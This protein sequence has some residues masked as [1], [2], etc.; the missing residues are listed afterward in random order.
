MSADMARPW[1]AVVTRESLAGGVIVP[2][3]TRTLRSR[4]EL[5]ALRG[6]ITA[7]M[8]DCD[9]PGAD[10]ADREE[11][12]RLLRYR[13]A[14]QDALRGVQAESWQPGHPGDGRLA[15]RGGPEPADCARAQ[16]GWRTSVPEEAPAR[17]GSGRRLG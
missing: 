4:D 7:A 8:A 17:P 9:V 6:L 15:G 12:Q 16:P 13:A 10:A 2:S 1:L 14:V 3:W 5:T 11:W